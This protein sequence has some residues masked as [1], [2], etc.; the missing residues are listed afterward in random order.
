MKE[1][2]KENCGDKETRREIGMLNGNI[3]RNR[4]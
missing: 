1:E 3:G 4:G 2:N